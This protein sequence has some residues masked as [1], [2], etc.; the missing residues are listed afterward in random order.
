M[1]PICQT[2]P[3]RVGR[4]CGAVTPAK[5]LDRL[6]SCPESRWEETTEVEIAPL[7]RKELDGISRCRGSEPW[8]NRPIS[9]IL[10]VLEYNIT[11]DLVLEGIRRQT[12]PSIVYIIDTG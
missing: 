10:P 11:L 7:R 3:S 4:L 9:V 1:N 5:G 8:K 2:C 12:V 6:P